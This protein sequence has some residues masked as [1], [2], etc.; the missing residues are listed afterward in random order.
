M[1][2]KM[3][4]HLAREFD[5]LAT[6][7]A[8]PAEHPDEN[9]WA[10]LADSLLPAAARADVL[11][12]ASVC[13]P[14]RR[15]LALLAGEADEIAEAA[16]SLAM[17]RSAPDSRIIRLWRWPAIVAA[18]AILLLAVGIRLY[19]DVWGNT[20]TAIGGVAVARLL[21][22]E[23]PLTRFGVPLEKQVQPIESAPALAAS[24][25]TAMLGKLSPAL[26]GERPA[27]ATLLL[28][29]RASLSAHAYQ[30]AL[31]YAA[32]WKGIAPADPGA[33]NAYGLA[34][35]MLNRMG[36]ARVAFE[37]AVALAPD[38]PEYQLNA[39]LAADRSGAV[40]TAREHLLRLKSLAPTDPPP[41]EIDAWLKR[42]GP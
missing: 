38:R 27:A 14:C 11:R 39:A 32:R 10:L 24:E 42:L 23:A 25:Y 9:A 16:G 26:R 13:G 19:R 12:H 40:E 5:R 6:R 21:P 1:S 36:D 28:A 8:G 7:A 29:T 37:H 41:A 3:A 15:R 17:K 31:A 34:S 33:Y 18:A 22:A 2:E 20:S 35:F 30:D 4:R